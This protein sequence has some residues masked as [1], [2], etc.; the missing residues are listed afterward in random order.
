MKT[1]FQRYKRTERTCPKLHGS[2]VALSRF[3]LRPVLFL[4]IFF[5]FPVPCCL[6]EMGINHEIPTSLSIHGFLMGLLLWLLWNDST[7]LPNIWL[8]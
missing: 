7:L 5:S 1:A 8:K 2:L 3:E 6:E 4:N